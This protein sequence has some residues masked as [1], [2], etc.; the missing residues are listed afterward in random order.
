M[1]ALSLSNGRASNQIMRLRGNVA[2]TKQMPMN[3]TIIDFKISTL[4]YFF[5]Y[6]I[7]INNP[8]HINK[9]IK[10]SSIYK[11]YIFIFSLKNYSHPFWIDLSLNSFPGKEGVNKVY[12]VVKKDFFNS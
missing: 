10:T 4:K 5:Y 6:L 7:I 12:F 3:Q 9:S 8:E 1:I 11:S 2:M